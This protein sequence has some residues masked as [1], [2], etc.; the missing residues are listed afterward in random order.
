[1]DQEGLET[2]LLDYHAPP[3]RG[4]KRDKIERVWRNAVIQNS[5]GSKPLIFSHDWGVPKSGRILLDFVE[6]TKGASHAEAA[7]RIQVDA[8]HRQI[9]LIRALIRPADHSLA[10][11]QVCSDFLSE[12][13]VSCEQVCELIQLF[14]EP[15]ARTS[16]LVK[17]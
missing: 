7:P 5:G 14:K 1:M 4:G 10:I 15:E 11:L 9:A 6:I 3:R 8:L 2:R 13:Y 12:H 17:T 16:L